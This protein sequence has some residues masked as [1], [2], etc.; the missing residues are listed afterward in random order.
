MQKSPDERGP[1]GQFLYLELKNHHRKSAKWLATKLQE[2]GSPL[3]DSLIRRWMSGA[4]VPQEGHEAISNIAQALGCSEAEVKKNHELSLAWFKQRKE[5]AQ[6]KRRISRV[7]SNDATNLL[8]KPDTS[9]TSRGNK[10]LIDKRELLGD[11]E[12]SIGIEEVRPIL[13]T[14]ICFLEQLPEP[15]NRNDELLLMIHGRTATIEEFAEDLQPR[16]YEAVKSALQKGWKV[17]H[18]VRLD[19]DFERIKKMVRGVL[20][21]VGHEGKYEPRIFKQKYVLP[22]AESFML[23]PSLNEGMIFYAGGQPRYVDSAIYIKDEIQINI[24]KRH[25]Y[26]L[27]E[28]MN[29]VFYIWKCYSDAIS[30]LERADNAPGNRIVILKRL[31]NIQRPNGSYKPNSSWAKAHQLANHLDVDEL[32]EVLKFRQL[33]QEKLKRHSFSYDC[34]Y[35]FTRRCIG[36]FLET[37]K[38]PSL[39]E[40]TASVDDR[41]AQILTYQD[42]LNYPHYAMALSEEAIFQA[43]NI[44]EELIRSTKFPDIIPNFCEVLENHLVLMQIPIKRKLS[45]HSESKWIA[46]EEPIIVKAFYQYL[47]DI[48]ETKIPKARKDKFH[49]IHWLEEE[50]KRLQQL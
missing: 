32:H 8:V 30:R 14:A 18:G 23:V 48:W 17:I 19:D 35:I 44:S 27:K 5:Q 31:S 1:F 10:V 24:L 7:Q 47:L 16:W 40:Y 13:E 21:L 6:R 26:Q 20:L 4:R 46:I 12:K 3:D 37:G 41:I 49:I 45:Q 50:K 33:R 15:K 29:P 42:L 9:L 36:N 43:P 2:L 34:K 39:P 28:E 38:E 22:V 11:G 25:F